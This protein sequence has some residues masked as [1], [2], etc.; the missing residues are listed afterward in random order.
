[1]RAFRLFVRAV[2]E[3]R[4]NRSFTRAAS[5]SF[6]CILSLIPLSVLFFS[7]AGLLGG[8]DRIIAY[9]RQQVFPLLAPE[10][11]DE[12]RTWLDDNI[13][14]EAFKAGPTGLV[15]VLAVVALM[16][17]A[18]GLFTVAERY[19]NAIW[20]V[21]R[22]RPF[23]RRA[24]VFWI[25]LTTSPFLIAASMYVSEMLVPEG[26]VIDRMT[27]RV[28]ILGAI[29]E[30]LVPLLIGTLGFTCVYY[31][32]P[33]ARVRARSALLGALVAAVLWEASKRGFFVY[34]SNAGRVTSFYGQLAAVP[35]FLVWVYVTWLVLL[36]GAQLAFVHQYRDALLVPSSDE[37]GRSPVGLG[38]ALLRRAASGQAARGRPAEGP[39]LA[40]ELGVGEGE[41]D[42]VARVLAREGY[43]LEVAGDAG[44]WVLARRPEAVDL[45]AV[46][47]LLVREEFPREMGE[48]AAAGPSAQAW[49]GFCS[50]L[51][52]RT[53]AALQ[54]EE[55]GGAV[56]G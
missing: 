24:G 52:G 2:S 31:F 6:A 51:R 41:L 21:D 32:L 15:N 4:Q 11:Q 55:R 18:L 39:M 35:L 5:L 54:E 47:R 19:L 14:R 20:K 33:A 30:L 13:S 9:V 16:T 27:E 1:V 48:S 3:F 26:G 8:G 29:Y 17:A 40:R 7:F 53:L 34:V 22:V 10:F 43:V 50:A 45:E 38:L 46:A 56:S 25:L 28:W 37:G 23:L 44:S 42:R 36:F 49:E 12:L